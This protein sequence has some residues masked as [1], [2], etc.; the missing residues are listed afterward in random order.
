MF[1]IENQPI[2]QIKDLKHRL[3]SKKVAAFKIYPFH[4]YICYAF[5]YIFTC[6]DVLFDIDGYVRMHT[7]A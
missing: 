4:F 5:V 3:Q 1:V 2:C 7:D 6:V